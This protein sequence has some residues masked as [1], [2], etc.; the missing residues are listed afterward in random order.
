MMNS[1]D[2]SVSPLGELFGHF[3]EVGQ[4][5]QA[6]QRG[7]RQSWQ[8][9]EIGRGLALIDPMSAIAPM[10]PVTSREPCVPMVGGRR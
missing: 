6:P 3:A 10:S 2:K 5:S 9:A 8:V 4:P 7:R 1:S